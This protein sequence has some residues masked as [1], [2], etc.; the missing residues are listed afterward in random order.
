MSY[1]PRLK[2]DYSKKIIKDLQGKLELKN[3]MQ[4]PT[5]DKIVISRGVGAAVSDKKLID[6]AVE[7]LTLISGQK[8]VATLSKK[9]V[10]SFKLR[11]GT[12]IGAKVT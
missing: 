10:A 8:A 6:H 11:K 4:V 2:D 7:E 3:V 1:S 12:P 5:L 9:D